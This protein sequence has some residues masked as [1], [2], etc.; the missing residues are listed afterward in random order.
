MFD[1]K[2]WKQYNV[3]F[4]DRHNVIL[5]SMTHSVRRPNIELIMPQL[6]RDQT[7][8]QGVFHEA[9]GDRLTTAL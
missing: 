1:S 3:G 7:Y 5:G 8:E 9:K 2:G 6:D 4:Q